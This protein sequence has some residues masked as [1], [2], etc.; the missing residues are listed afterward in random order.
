MTQSKSLFKSCC[1]SKNAGKN[2]DSAS[3]TGGHLVLSFPDADTPI[4]WRKDFNEIK[5]ASFCVEDRSKKDKPL[6]VLVL[7]LQNSDK[8]ENQSEDIASFQ[9]KDA[10]VKALQNVSQAMAFGQ[11]ASG[12]EQASKQTHYATAHAGTEQSSAKSGALGF[13]IWTLLIICAGLLWFMYASGPK[14]SSVRTTATT[15]QQSPQS[16][17]TSGAQSQQNAVGVPLNADAFLLNR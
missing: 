3:F 17:Q 1:N 5:S 12:A 9:Q 11:T 6:H 4:V 7:T 14:P 13:G 15:Q 10:A 16:S 2:Q 8:K